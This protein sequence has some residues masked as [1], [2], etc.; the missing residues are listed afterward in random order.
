L[1]I[2]CVILT[3]KGVVLA[4]IAGHGRR[5]F[6]RSDSIGTL[7]HQM[8]QKMGDTRFSRRLIHCANPV[9][10]HMGHDGRPVIFHHNDLHP[11]I[12]DHL[13]RIINFCLCG[14]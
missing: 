11:I 6:S 2:G 7:E 9:P 5:E 4:P 10:D 13:F 14:P 12:Q 3:G 8:F 1:E